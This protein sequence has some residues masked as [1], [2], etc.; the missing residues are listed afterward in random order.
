MRFFVIMALVVLGIALYASVG[1]AQEAPL[2]LGETS[3][4][5][6]ACGDAID[7]AQ[8]ENVPVRSC[9]RVSE[10]IAANRATMVVRIATPLGVFHVT[11]RYRKSL[12]SGQVLEVDPQ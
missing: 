12:W 3:L 7:L 5:L 8:R 1:N 10:E 4:L 9:R 11:S 6:L 2:D